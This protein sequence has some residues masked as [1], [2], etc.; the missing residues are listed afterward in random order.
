[1]VLYISSPSVTEGQVDPERAVRRA[2]LSSNVPFVSTLAA[3]R[4]IAQALRSLKSQRLGVKALQ[5]YFPDYKTEFVLPGAGMPAREDLCVSA[6]EGVP[7]A[8]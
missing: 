6:T 3:A 4:A 2:A 5:D 1:M 7:S 8:V